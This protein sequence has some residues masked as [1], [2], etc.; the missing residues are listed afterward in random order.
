MENITLSSLPSIFKMSHLWKIL[1]YYGNFH[2]WIWIMKNLNK[3]ANSLWDENKQAFI[4]W[5][6]LYKGQARICDDN[7]DECKIW[8][9][10]ETNIKY[11][12]INIEK[13]LSVFKNKELEI[14][15]YFLISEK[16]LKMFLN[17]ALNIL[18]EDMA[19]IF[20]NS[21]I[22]HAI[23]ISYSSN[24][25]NKYCEY[26]M[27]YWNKSNIPKYFPSFEWPNF[28]INI[29]NFNRNTS[30][31]LFESIIKG[32][33]TYPVIL[34]KSSEGIKTTQIKS[35]TIILPTK[36]STDSSYPYI[37]SKYSNWRDQ[38]CWWKP[39]KIC[40]ESQTNIQQIVSLLWN[41]F[42]LIEEIYSENID[43]IDMVKLIILKRSLKVKNL[44]NSGTPFKG[45]YSRRTEYG[46]DTSFVISNSPIIAIYDSNIIPLRFNANSLRL[47]GYVIG[48][49]PLSKE[50]WILIKYWKFRLNNVWIQYDTNFEQIKKQLKDDYNGI[51]ENLKDTELLIIKAKN[52]QIVSTWIHNKLDFVSKLTNLQA[53]TISYWFYS[54][55]KATTLNLNSI[56]DRVI[57]V[58][59]KAVITKY[60]YNDVD[61]WKSIVKRKNTILNNELYN[62]HFLGVKDKF[63]LENLRNN[64]YKICIAKKGIAE[65]WTYINHADLLILLQR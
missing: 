63:N 61:F 25:S 28:A 8:E 15:S 32:V 5:G 13:A 51:L 56:P 62:Y 21:L 48:V 20:D 42:E 10:Y 22:K 55:T 64:M 54:D 41:K 65:Y 19:I 27:I 7:L 26:K 46:D 38:Y 9:K 43:F 14:F 59:P 12:W 30:K 1:P 53:I 6:E 36:E 47:Y 52:T 2:R 33:L 35:Q 11:S 39:T 23:E 24:Q 34:Q 44:L 50:D 31:S 60:L 37:V 3:E 17:K 49:I 16:I 45:D 29:W 4:N 18:S 57:I 40:I 58:L